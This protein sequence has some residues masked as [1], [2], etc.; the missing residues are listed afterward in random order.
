MIMLHHIRPSLWS[1]FEVGEGYRTRLA[2]PT[3][4]SGSNSVRIFLFFQNVKKFLISG[5]RYKSRQ[6][7]GSAI[8]QCLRCLHKSVPWRISLIDLE[9]KSLIFNR[10]DFK[11]FKAWDVMFNSLFESND[12]EILYSTHLFTNRT[13]FALQIYVN[14]ITQTKKCIQFR[15]IQ[16]V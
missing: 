12:F 11:P 7:L 15:K 4:L 9:T 10:F 3:V 13:T 5:G 6:A 14:L 16:V 8:S 2:T 1:N